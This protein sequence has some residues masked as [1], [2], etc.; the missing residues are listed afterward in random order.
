VNGLVY[1]IDSNGSLIW[2]TQLTANDDPEVRFEGA[3][4]IDGLGQIY[5]S[6]EPWEQDWDVYTVTIYALGSIGNILWTED[7]EAA[8]NPFQEHYPSVAAITPDGNIV[9]NGD[10]GVIFT[11]DGELVVNISYP[12]VVMGAASEFTVYPFTGPP[13]IGPDGEIAFSNVRCPLFTQSG[14]YLTELLGPDVY[15][16]GSN[17]LGTGYMTAPVWG[18]GGISLLNWTGD[19]EYNESFEFYVNTRTDY[20]GIART[21]V[22]RYDPLF[23][24]G[25]GSSYIQGV[26]EDGLGYL[27]ASSLKLHAF[28]PIT[29][30]SLYP[31]V[32]HR[33]SMWTYARPSSHMTTPVIGEDGWLYMGYG[34]DILAI[35]D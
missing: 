23:P 28:S 2:S 26:A 21:W 17:N 12:S 3:V 15:L 5:V 22:S 9:V 29:S 35:G 16:F 33:H 10:Q 7:I 1:C 4:N 34:N 11:P 24:Y 25:G 20:G 6:S 32:T 13:S 27:Y 8:R 19:N 30:G 14:I 31:Y 18:V